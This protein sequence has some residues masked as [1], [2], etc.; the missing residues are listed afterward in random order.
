MWI[1]RSQRSASF[2][3]R[4]ENTLQAVL[5][6]TVCSWILFLRTRESI[7]N[8]LFLIVSGHS[9]CRD[10]EED[11]T[12]VGAHVPWRLRIP[13]VPMTQHFAQRLTPRSSFFRGFP[14]MQITPEYDTRS[15]SWLIQEYF[16]PERIHD[17]R[18]GYKTQR[19]L[20][21][22]FGTC[23]VFLVI[24]HLAWRC[25]KC[26]CRMT[27]CWSFLWHKTRYMWNTL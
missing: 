21:G 10:S 23:Y 8:E 3:I 6:F 4:N 7:C 20:I 22:C 11:H 15:E 12:K 1:I 2:V 26:H 24:A 14:L 13:Q 27:W 16:L 18:S 19:N 9:A 17:V 25:L 5:S